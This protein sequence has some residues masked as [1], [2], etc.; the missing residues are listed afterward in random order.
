[1]NMRLALSEFERLVRLALQR[2]LSVE[3]LSLTARKRD[4]LLS[5]VPSVMMQICLV[6]CTAISNKAS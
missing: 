2:S 3:V 4:G 6:V 1:M 5:I